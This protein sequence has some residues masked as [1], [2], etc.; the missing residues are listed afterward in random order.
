METHLLSLDANR[1]DE[2]LALRRAYLTG[3]TVRSE[4]IRRNRPVRVVDYSETFHDGLFEIA[5]AV[6]SAPPDTA[7]GDLAR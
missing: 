7:A 2:R 6:T 1:A 5:I 4:L 3:C